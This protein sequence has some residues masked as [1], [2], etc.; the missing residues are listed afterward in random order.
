MTGNDEDVSSDDEDS[1]DT[2]RCTHG[3][4]LC[5]LC[6]VDYTEIN[7]IARN[8]MASSGT[9]KPLNIENHV[10]LGTRCKLVDQSGKSPPEDLVG[11]VVGSRMALDDTMDERVPHYVIE[12]EQDGERFNHRIDDFHDTWLVWRD[13][14]WA[15]PLPLAA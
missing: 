6:C 14:K 2:M 15:K 10:P 4:E 7:E 12:V 11:K 13:G 3:L 9:P 8:S 1:S 5:G